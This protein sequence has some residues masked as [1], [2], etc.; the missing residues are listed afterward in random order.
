MQDQKTKRIRATNTILPPIPDK[1]YFT[2]GEVSTLCGIKTHVLRYWEQEF[3]QLEP[4]KRK[5][6]RR[7]YQRKDIVLVRKLKDLLYGQGFT[8]EGARA[9]LSQVTE[10]KQVISTST[11]Q[12]LKSLQV[13]VAELEGL[14]KELK[15]SEEN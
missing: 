9:Q 3:E 5:G 12:S 13:A 11:H 1:L 4:C 15:I 7:Y 10:T 14:L 6:N 2:I 8:I